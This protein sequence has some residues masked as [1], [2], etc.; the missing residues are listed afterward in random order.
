MHVF[1]APSV[2]VVIRASCGNQVAVEIV[3]RHPKEHVFGNVYLEM[4]LD[5]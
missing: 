1:T 2:K 5:E 3:E 4:T